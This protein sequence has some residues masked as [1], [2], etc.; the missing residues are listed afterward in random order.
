VHEPEG[1]AERYL[2]VGQALEVAAELGLSEVDVAL[3]DRRP[4][5]PL[6]DQLRR[7]SRPRKWAVDDPLDV[8]VAEAIPTAA[9]CS[10]PSAL[11]SKPSRWPYKTRFGFCTSAWRIK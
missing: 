1:A 11:R 3:Q 6:V 9:A 2:P 5:Q 10:L 8:L 4:R 7:L